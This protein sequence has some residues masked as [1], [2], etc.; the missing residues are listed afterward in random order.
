[1]MASSFLI[2]FSK[3]NTNIYPCILLREKSHL[4]KGIYCWYENIFEICHAWHFINIKYLFNEGRIFS[5]RFKKCPY[6]FLSF[7]SSHQLYT[8]FYFE[9]HSHYTEVFNNKNIFLEKDC[10]SSFSEPIINFQPNTLL[11]S[12]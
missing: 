7:K 12:K 5:K 6:F 4:K 8:C 2:I 9:Q 11:V 1:M 3:I 10:I